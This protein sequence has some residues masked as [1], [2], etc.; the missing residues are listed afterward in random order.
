MKVM[1]IKRI[2]TLLSR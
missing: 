1:M 2:T